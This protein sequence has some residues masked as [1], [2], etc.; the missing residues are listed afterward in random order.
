M[1][2]YPCASAITFILRQRI[3]S[4]RSVISDQMGTRLQSCVDHSEKNKMASTIHWTIR[5]FT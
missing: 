4:T 2:Q 1:T 5:R 3:S